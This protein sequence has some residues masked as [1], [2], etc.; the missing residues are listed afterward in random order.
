MEGDWLKFKIL[1]KMAWL[2]WGWLCL[3]V[4]TN[5][6]GQNSIQW[7]RPVVQFSV[8]YSKVF[9]KFQSVL[10]IFILKVS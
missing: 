10:I 6:E 4:I 3:E 7:Y 8:W 9:L 5:S 2:W 1:E